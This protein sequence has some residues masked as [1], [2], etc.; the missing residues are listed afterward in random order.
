MVYLTYAKTRKNTTVLKKYR[1]N[2]QAYKL[3]SLIFTNELYTVVI[4]GV[5]P[6]FVGLIVN[7]IF[8]Y[9]GRTIFPLDAALFFVDFV[10]SIFAL[11][12]IYKLYKKYRS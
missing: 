8:V 4:I 12:F 9:L 1:Q 7:M 3:L 2:P 6:S 5:V 10:S 11:Y